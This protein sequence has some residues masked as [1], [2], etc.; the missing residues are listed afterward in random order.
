MSQGNSEG[1]SETL[2]EA[3]EA[4]VRDI[5]VIDDDPANLTAVEV[6]LGDLGRRIVKAQSGR[7]ALRHLLEQDFALILLDVQMPE[8][9]GFETARL[10]RSRDR[11]AHVPIIF[12]TAYERDDDEVLRGYRLG[13]VDFMFKPIVPEVL[14][15]KASVFVALQERTE[16]V[17]S[18][19]VRLREMERREHDQQLAEERR[20]WETEQLRQENRRKDEFLAILSHELRN[21]L[22]SIVAGLEF[23]GALDVPDDRFAGAHTLM[24]RQIHH[25]TRLVDDLLDI[26]RISQGKIALDKCQMDLREAVEHAVESVCLSTSDRGH[27]VEIS[28]PESPVWVHG[29]RDRLIQVVANLLSNAVRYTEADGHIEVELTAESTQ[30]HLRV[31]DNGRGIEPQA[32]DHIFELFT[33]EKTDGQGLGLGLTLVHRLVQMHGGTVDVRSD[34]PGTGSEFVVSLPLVT[35]ASAAEDGGPSAEKEAV[36]SPQYAPLS[37]ALVDDDQDVREPMRMLLETW[38]HTVTDAKSG[39]E[40]V[41]LV[42]AQRPDVVLMDIGMPGVDGYEAARQVRQTLRESTPRLIAMTGFGSSRDRERSRAAGFDAHI[43]K[44]ARPDELKRILRGIDHDNEL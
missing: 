24:N 7:E 42:V 41:E 1:L 10:I 21:P 15:A 26:S 38:G 13:A 37:I 32:I 12:I 8:M 30:T 6:A 27:A 29:D 40:G 20:R 33:Q 17:R 2:S 28:S 22:A 16:E 19:Q 25:L 35:E 9:D 18:H 14:R 34:G 43:V 4:E 39:E 5:L 31:A 44:P 3:S 11:S 23:I 36:E